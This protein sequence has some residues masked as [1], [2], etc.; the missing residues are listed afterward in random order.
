MN[1]AATKAF[2]K[3]ERY[4]VGLAISLYMVFQ[5]NA[6]L[7]HGSW[8]QD[9]RIHRDWIADAVMDPWQYFAHYENGRTN[10][11]LY[12]LLGALVYKA[13]G[14]VHYL[15][16]LAMLSAVL[17]AGALLLLYRIIRS[18]MREPLIR[19]SCFIFLL[20]LPFAMIHA[21]VLAS[22]ALAPPI[23]IAVVYL[24]ITLDAAGSRKDYFG[25]ILGIGLLLTAG[26]GVKFTFG[27]LILASFLSLGALVRTGS[28]NRQR[29]LTG[30]CAL[31]VVPVVPAIAEFYQYRTQQTYNNGMNLKGSE[32][33]LR[34][35]VFFREHDLHIL[36]APPFSERASV[37]APAQG[38]TPALEN[39]LILKNKY[40]YPALLELAIFTDILNI[41]QYDPDDSYFGRRTPGNQ[42]KMRLAVRTGT[43]FFAFVVFAAAFVL[44]KSCY[45]TFV[46][47]R[48]EWITMSIMGGAASLYYLNI[49]AGLP[50]V[51]AY[52]A[53]YWLPRLVQ[54]A[55]LC[56]VVMAFTAL[57]GWLL[58]RSR[59]FAW[60]CLALVLFQSAVHAS[61]L[62]PWGLMRSTG[63]EIEVQVQRPEAIAP[64]E[65]TCP[66]CP[67]MAV[68]VKTDTATQGSWKGV[69]GSRGFAIANDEKSFPEY[70]HITLPQNATTWVEHAA[71][72]GSALQNV[73][74][75]TARVASTW[76]EWDSLSID[77]YL[78]DGHKHELALYCVD[79]DS[80]RRAQTVDILDG[81]S[82][83]ILDSRHL[84]AFNTGKYLVWSI[85][86]HVKIRV[87]RTGE[88]NAVVS[89]LFLD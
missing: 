38:D 26:V 20:F 77:V 54:P 80:T 58:R 36:D 67:T 33:N 57:D 46:T 76:W 4:G 61:F 56:F 12:H 64:S 13:T 42:A 51:R 23:F 31:A 60:A 82:N 10:P 88:P 66:D 81:D 53:G 79:W 72:S 30:V 16:V 59:A 70:A 55:L 89:G 73:K 6:A 39:E 44:F 37:P 9:F 49:V 83:R 71:G 62:W 34:S 47:G 25:R 75:R 1:L 68:F 41:Y 48:R 11:P 15:E 2:P 50:F 35:I 84:S 29:F 24:L 8:G 14:G 32:M 52:Y 85:R 43:I 69:Y 7:H 17:N 40:S 63:G 86:G 22:D 74:S 65:P 87:A 18:Q 21:V 3:L 45:V 28:I 78:R 5:I 19:L 27:S